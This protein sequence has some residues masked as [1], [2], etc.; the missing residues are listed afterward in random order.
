[1]RRRAASKTPWLIAGIV[2][3]LA[4]IVVAI[5]MQPWLRVRRARHD[6]KELVLAL[7]AYAIEFREPLT[8]PTPV[9]CAAL[10]GDNPRREAI[11]EGY[12]L[13]ADGEFLDPYGTP[14]RF[15]T[16][17]MRVHSCGP[18]KQDEAGAGD[19]IASWQ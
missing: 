9:V 10:R 7:Q 17:S 1:M 12:R 11:V 13:N 5:A 18:N 19:D 2:V 14:Y 6:V 3:V 8:G 4:I 16:D 15:Q